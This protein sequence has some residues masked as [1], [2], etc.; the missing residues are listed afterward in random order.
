[1]NPERTITRRRFL[2]RATAL[3]AG[4]PLV[5]RPGVL[6][7]PGL[8]GPSDRVTVGF[9]G[10]GGRGQQL[11]RQLPADSQIVAICDCYV[12]RSE[13]A[14][15][16]FGTK[17]TVYQDY[18][19]ILERKDIEAVVIP[20][21]DHGRVIPCIH[22]CQAGKDV[23]AEKPLTVTIAEGRVLAR[24]V[25]KHRRVFQT[26]T[27][28]RSMELNE[29]ACRFVR[30]GGIGRLHTVRCCNYP[31]PGRYTGL[32][33][34]PIPEGLNWD[35]W[36][37]RTELR[38]YNRNLQF[39]W[40]AWRSYSG[41]EMTNW[42]AHGMD[43][44]QWALGTSESGPVEVWPVTPGP[45]GQVHMRYAGG[46]LVKLEIDQGGPLGGAIFIGSKGE[47]RID[48]NTYTVTPKELVTDAPDAS[49]A[50]KW[51]LADWP[52]NYHLRNWVMCIKSRK[53][54][55]SDAEVGHRS[56]SVC[57]LANIAREVGRTLRWNPENEIFPGDP[58]ANTYL[59]RPRRTGYELPAV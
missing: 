15:Q 13:Q 49:L 7:A 18:R 19:K 58:E 11:M 39:G 56:I 42:G 40:M 38:P 25:K 48:R 24:A 14:N 33:E 57:H 22:A 31:G 34:Q 10:T 35:M 6:A 23:Y 37:S 59:E 1:M 45:N 4:A 47:I 29:F 32:P 8:P 46:V 27:Q 54:P 20:T 9:I 55:A 43:Q 26:G 16:R 44:V 50:E 41:G 53:R 5:V 28:Q 2:R 52:A 21:T 51:R 17:Y 12:K 3:A 30:E 36:C